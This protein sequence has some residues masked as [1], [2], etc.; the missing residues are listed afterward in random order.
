MAGASPWSPAGPGTLITSEHV[1]AVRE[2]LASELADLDVQGSRVALALADQ[3]QFL[4]ALGAARS[5][6]AVATLMSS[7]V[8]TQR[9]PVEL[10]QRI[11]R[12]EPHV[13]IVD[14]AHEALV[15]E[16]A[17]PAVGLL[18]VREDGP[19]WVRRPLDVARVRCDPAVTMMVF[20]S[21]STS[22]PKG[23]LL[24]RQNV[25]FALAAHARMLDWGERDTYLA[26]LPLTH[27]L[28]IV[29]LTSILAA[30]GRAVVS[31]GFMFPDRVVETC[32]EQRV[33]VM[34]LVPYFLARLLSR[35]NLE[36]LPA[37]QL[38][39]SSAPIVTADVSR[40]QAQLPALT[41]LHTYGL[42]EAFRSTLLPPG[43]VPER[44]PSIGKPIEGV[45]VELRTDEG[46]R[47][48][49]PE[50][51]G[52]AWLKGPNVMHGYFGEAQLTALALRDGWLCTS[53]IMQRSADGY[54]T[55]KGRTAEV[56]NGGGEKLMCHEVEAIIYQS[57]RVEELIVL[58]VSS[59]HG[60]DHVVAVVA[61]APGERPEIADVRRA[62]AGRV[63]SVFIPRALVLVDRLPRRE[64]G[65]ID[66]AA[67]A[68]IALEYL[69][70]Q[71]QP[72][73]PV[74]GAGA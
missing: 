23:V 45:Q 68:R 1:R 10:R 26:C 53:D 36:S 44:L 49:D 13:I 39:I 70:Q 55:L 54:L 69:A 50:A 2:A 34:S 41:V 14:V 4:G 51:C 59:Q 27:V 38:V 32:R 37:R 29:N 25:D 43:D 73:P 64:N 21:G 58:S 61:P 66:R 12:C 47:L 48:D 5:R 60:C 11:Q 15:A 20:T 72:A 71:V 24:T 33:T 30:G 42:T 3:A 65:K 17:D 56:L 6:G 74:D 52:V 46:E 9:S 8:P 22:M 7:A 31:P 63:H 28:G 67:V 40:L 16:L 57:M 18:A 35:G 62:C 19:R